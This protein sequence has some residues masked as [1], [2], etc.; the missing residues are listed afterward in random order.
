MRLAFEIMEEQLRC[1]Q[2]MVEREEATRNPN[3]NGV[4]SNNN[5]KNDGLEEGDKKKAD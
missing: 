1:M 3:G 2:A 5:E 4:E